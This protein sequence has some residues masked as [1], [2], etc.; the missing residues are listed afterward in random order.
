MEAWVR[1][2]DGRS[3]KADLEMRM[4]MPMPQSLAQA[5]QAYFY[6]SFNGG[7]EEISAA[8]GWNF[9]AAEEYGRWVFPGGTV[10]MAQAFWNRLAQL[11]TH[12]PAACRAQH[13]R[14]GCLVADVRLAP[15]DRV[16]VTYKDH[17]GGVHSLLAK[18]V[19]MAGAKMIAKYILPDVPKMDEAKFSAMNAL[20]FWAYLVVNVLLD[21]PIKRDFYDIFLL[22]DGDFPLSSG[23]VEA[24]SRVVDMLSGHYAR[25]EPI[26]RSVLTLYW[27]M[28]WASSRFRVI[29]PDSWQ[30]FSS[31]VVP[32]IRRMLSLLEV[33]QSAVRQVRLT[34]WGHAMPNHRPGLIASGVIDNLRRPFEDRIYFVNQDNW[35]LP[36]VENCLLDAQIYMEQVAK[37]LTRRP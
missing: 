32:Q 29:W 20:D 35:A 24:R 23:D 10:Y 26:P 37:V 22:G 30:R 7:A 33:P 16:Q 25:R 1:E 4:G 5:V 2:L 28:P 36:A 8:G 13:L 9:L 6:S 3:F 19:V 21:S 11:E 15:N 17:Q 18:R 14:S 31:E 27:P 34:R 12:N